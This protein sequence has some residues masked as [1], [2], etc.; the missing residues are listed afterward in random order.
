MVVHVYVLISAIVDSII[1]LPSVSVSLKITF[2]A[3]SVNF[4][5]FVFLLTITFIDFVVNVTS[6]GASATVKSWENFHSLL[7]TSDFLSRNKGR[8][9]YFTS[10]ILSRQILTFIIPLSRLKVT[11]S[12]S[13]LIETTV[14]FKDSAVMRRI[15]ITDIFFIVEMII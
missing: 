4:T 13:F 12:L 10:T 14:A 2:P 7:T 1:D 15:R 3:R 5:A 9:V 8:V 11:P 6:L